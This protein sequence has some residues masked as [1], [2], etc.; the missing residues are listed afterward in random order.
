MKPTHASV[1]GNSLKYTNTSN[2]T[3]ESN[4]FF[5]NFKAKNTT[6]LANTPAHLILTPTDNSKILNFINLNNAGTST[7]KTS[8]AFKK[9]QFFSKTNPQ[10]L[11]N[12]TSDFSLKYNKIF[13]IY[14]SDN[15][16]FETSNYGLKRQHNYNSSASLNS[17]FTTKLDQ[18]SLE[19]SFSYCYGTQTEGNLNHNFIR[20]GKNNFHNTNNLYEDNFNNYFVSDNVLNLS[21]TK[22]NQN[23]ITHQQLNYVKTNP[24]SNNSQFSSSDKS[25]RLIENLRLHTASTNFD[26]HHL[27]KIQQQTGALSQIF[28][29]NHN[30]DNLQKIVST[31]TIFPQAHT[32]TSFINSTFPSLSFDKFDQNANPSSILRSKEES[33]PNFIFDTY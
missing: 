12:A 19:K 20:G 2:L 23:S 28:L 5:K 21:I 11:F 26:N 31:K 30:V 9:I 7:L 29:K 3:S 33:A 8:T 16:L 13:N 22:Q 18:N 10:N 25:V 1:V 17:N 4:T 32:P 6:R 15:E 27:E 14:K 24:K